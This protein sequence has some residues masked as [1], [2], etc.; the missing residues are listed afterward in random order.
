MSPLSLI[1]VTQMFR[2]ENVIS[3]SLGYVSVSVFKNLRFHYSILVRELKAIL[4]KMV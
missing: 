3:H 1:K 4:L 2:S